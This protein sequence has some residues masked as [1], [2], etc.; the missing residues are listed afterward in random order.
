MFLRRNP[1]AYASSSARAGA[2]SL[3]PVGRTLLVV[4]LL[5]LAVACGGDSGDGASILARAREGLRHL[6]STPVH[7]RIGVQAPVPIDRSFVLSADQMPELDLAGWAKNPKRISCA[8]GFD[9]ARADV[10]VEA[11][12]RALGPLLPS[13]PVD[14]KDVHDAQVDVAVDKNGRTRYLHLHGDVHVMLLGDVP[15]EANLDV[16]P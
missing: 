16:E 9:C 10:D 1:A 2:V 4:T 11:A 3:L 12:L 5:P 8:D 14:P 7:M 6:G 15:F 13:L